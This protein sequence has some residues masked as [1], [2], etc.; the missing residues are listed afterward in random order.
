MAWDLSRG[1]GKPSGKGDV[2][3]IDTVK[4]GP[5]QEPLDLKKTYRIVTD[6]FLAVEGGDNFTVFKQGTGLQDMGVLDMEAIVAYMKRHPKENPLSK[7]Q[8]RIKCLGCPP[9]E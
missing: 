4:I 7:P 9:M 1:L 8:K 3:L 2:V 5:N 6:P